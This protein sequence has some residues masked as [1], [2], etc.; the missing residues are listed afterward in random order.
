MPQ[1]KKAFKWDILLVLPRLNATFSLTGPKNTHY[2]DFSNKSTTPPLS[3][4]YP[5]PTLDLSLS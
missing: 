1:V 3:K 2:I 5:R 4:I